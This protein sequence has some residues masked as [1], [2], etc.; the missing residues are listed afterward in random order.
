MIELILTFSSKYLIEFMM[1][2]LASALVFRFLTFRSSK[3]DEAYFTKFTREIEANIERDKH[4]QVMIED[5]DIYLSDILGRVNKKLPHRHV[6]FSKNK[7]VNRE[8][9]RDI[10]LREF[11]K[12]KNG[13]IASIQAESSV[14]N[15][16]TPPNF[17]EL[18]YR[19]MD[20]DTHWSKLMGRLPIDGLSRLIDVLPSIFI[21]LGVFGTFIGISMALPEIAKIDF[22]NIDGSGQT[23]TNFVVNVTF[24][25]KTSIAGIFFSLV[26]TFLN[27]LYPIKT[28]RHRIFKKVEVCLQM[29][30]Y[31]IQSDSNKEDKEDRRIFKEMLSTLKSISSQMEDKNLKKKAS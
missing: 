7:S 9:S 5:V 30:W 19:I 1:F 21:V 22:S 11:V 12:S 13:L 15:N 17:T 25:M 18:T 2:L 31:H 28:M 29:L 16:K 8:E 23:L 27:T 24:A 4:S 3:S 10:S 20:Q 14:Y 26:L 6:R